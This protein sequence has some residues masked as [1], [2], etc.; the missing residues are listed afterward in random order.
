MSGS[1]GP[2]FPSTPHKECWPWSQP[3]LEPSCSG[4][5]CVPALL[6]LVAA[7][8]AVLHPVSDRLQGSCLLLLELLQACSIKPACWYLDHS[9]QL[10]APDAT[11]YTAAAAP[12]ASAVQIVKPQRATLYCMLA[13][14]GFNAVLAASHTRR[15]NVLLS[16]PLHVIPRDPSFA[17]LG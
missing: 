2:P 4:P 8:V 16:Q 13:V 1:K 6:K 9:C 12:S 11:P 17:V 14:Q 5:W 15:P 7:L 10:A 3:P